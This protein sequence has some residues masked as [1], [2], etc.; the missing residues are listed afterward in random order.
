M[1]LSL[2]SFAALVVAVIVAVKLGSLT[3]IVQELRKRV[4]ELEKNR[5]PQVAPKSSSAAI[6]PP[7]PDFAKLSAVPPPPPVPAATRARSTPP[8]NWESVLGVKL[9]A[10]IG[11]LALFLGVVFWVKYAFENNLI[12]PGMRTLSGAVIGIVLVIV[13]LLPGVRRYRVPAQ[14]VCTTGILILYADIYGAHAFYNLIPL[15]ASIA[16]TWILTAIAL[17][18]STGLEAPGVSLLALVGGFLTPF[19]FRTTYGNPFVLFGYIAI[20]SCGLAW[21]SAL[22]R[23]N[24][25]IVLAA[26]GCI[27]IEFVW[28]AGAFGEVQANAARLVFLGMQGLFLAFCIALSRL[29]REDNSGI[30]AAA[31]TGLGT[32]LFAIVSIKLK[33][34]GFDL[35]FPFPIIFLGDAGLIGIAISHRAWAARSELL[36]GIVG[37]ALAFTALAEWQWYELVFLGSDSNNMAFTAIPQI[38]SVLAW[39]VAVF[40][41]FAAPPYLFSTKQLWPWMTASLAAMSQFWFVHALSDGRIPSSCEWLL[42]IGFALPAAIG[43][44]WLLNKEH[45]ALSSGDS[46]LA[47]QG[48]TVLAFISLIFPVQFDREWIT[49]GWAIEG[50]ALILLFRW[51]PNRRLRV[52][53]MIILAGAFVRL[54]F[55]PAVFDYHPRTRVAIFNWYLSV[56]GIAAACLFFAGRLFGEP[57]DSAYERRAPGILYALGGIVCFTLMNIEIADYFS[58]GPTLTFSFEGNFARDM[59]YTIA[60][61]AFALALLAFGI[62][63]KT[64][65]LRLAAIALLCCALAKLFLHDLD[66]L[67][68]LYRIAALISVAMIAIVASFAYQRFLSS[69]PKE[70]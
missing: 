30:A 45:L 49:L 7:L 65:P 26:I 36:L 52:F 32:L 11:G 50:V 69:G 4:D 35:D 41:L 61:A 10:W 14:S 62:S 57:R 6:P 13:A 22:K 8:I 39:H 31:I 67:S 40:L 16:L 28:A 23:W 46:R 47:S 55:N 1:I 60:W 48:A 9:F 5:S 18:L 12:T 70:S 19:L 38:D 44:A 58:I 3:A 63:R 24:Y 21:V 56:Y 53:A 64:R 66:N 25:L 15:T 17:F 34:R 27:I 29:N 2:L 51:I 54:I 33:F 20:L 68:Q 37:A 43:V 42:P 59:T